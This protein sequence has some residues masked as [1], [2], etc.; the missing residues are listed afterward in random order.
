MRHHVPHRRLDGTPLTIR[1]DDKKEVFRI[2]DGDHAVSVGAPGDLYISRVGHD[3]I[4]RKQQDGTIVFAYVARR[5]DEE[6]FEGDDELVTALVNE[7]RHLVR[8]NSTGPIA[9]AAT[10]GLSTL[11]GD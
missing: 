1:W 3:P 4:A 7:H 6:G 11:A 8:Y 10:S 5:T 2:Q 9:Q